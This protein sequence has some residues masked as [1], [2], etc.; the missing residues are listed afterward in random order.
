MMALDAEC[1]AMQCCVMGLNTKRAT[2][3]IHIA[4]GLLPAFNVRG[5]VRYQ[6]HPC[7]ASR[8][9][10]REI[11]WRRMH[12]VSERLRAGVMRRKAAWD[13]QHVLP[14]GLLVA[15]VV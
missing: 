5:D 13:Q 8:Q 9:E 12:G 2:P 14:F 15:A 3:Y 6:A 7:R 4:Q 11:Y 1:G 10:R